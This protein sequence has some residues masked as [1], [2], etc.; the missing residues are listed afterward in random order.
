[1]VD[2]RRACHRSDGAGG[3]PVPS[4]VRGYPVPD[5][6]PPGGTEVQTDLANHLPLHFD[7]VVEPRLLLESLPKLSKEPGNV[8]KVIHRPRKPVVER[9]SGSANN[10]GDR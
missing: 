2:E 1:A 5:L 4:P 6:T 3:E 9:F 7:G 8:G 10:V